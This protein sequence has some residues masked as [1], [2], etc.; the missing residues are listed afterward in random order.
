VGK[1][2]AVS[3]SSTSPVLPRVSCK[4]LGA[5]PGGGS[6]IRTGLSGGGLLLR[7]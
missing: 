7:V 4:D 2:Y 1:L 6:P 3:L 5:L